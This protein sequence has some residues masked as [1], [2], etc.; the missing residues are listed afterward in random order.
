MSYK[1]P[2]IATALACVA[3]PLFWVYSMTLKAQDEY[4]AQQLVDDRVKVES[5]L[6][7]ERAQSCLMAESS[8]EP[9]IF[10]QTVKGAELNESLDD[11]KET[12]T[13]GFLC[14]MDGSTVQQHL[15]EL[16]KPV[17]V[18]PS[19]LGEYYGW[20]IDRGLIAHGDLPKQFQKQFEIKEAH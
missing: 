2:A 7:L 20:L 6:A 16:I 12:H 13:G 5:S 10:L 9:G 11:L 8:L 1:S 14:A 19:S 18:E 17:A 3:T 4:Q 15:G